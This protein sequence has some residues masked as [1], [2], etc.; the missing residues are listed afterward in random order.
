MRRGAGWG[1]AAA[2]TLLA[3]RAVA[4]CALGLDPSLMAHDAGIPPDGTSGQ[5][6][7]ASKDG[8]DAAPTSSTGMTCTVDSDCVGVVS[9][10]SCVT[11]ATCDAVWHVCMLDVC[12]P[13][14]CQIASCDL[15]QKT[16]SAPTS[17]GFAV[18]VFHIAS[19]VGDWGPASSVAAAYPF[20]F[21]LTNNGVAAYN[22]ANPTGTVPPA[23]AVHGA[24][25]IPVAL[26]A[27]GRRVY[28]VGP[29]EGT[30]PAFRQAIAWID[31]PGDPFLTSLSASTAWVSTT[32]PTLANAVWNGATGLALTYAA[33]ADPTSTL[34]A[35]PDDSTSLV[36]SPIASLMAGAAI[37]ASSGNDLV[38]YLNGTSARHALFSLVTGVSQS[39]GQATAQQNIGAYGPLDDQAAFATGTD[40]TLLWSSAP[41]RVVDGG[42]TGIASTRLTWLSRADAGA[43]A[44]FLST[45]VH[46]DL[47]TY[48]AST[49]GTVV[50]PV[51]Y[52]DN[53]TAV[54]LAASGEDL[55]ATSVQ[56][57][58]RSANAIA[59]GQRAVISATPDAVGVAASH[60][61]AYVLVQDDA[62]NQ[63]STVYVV[64]PGCTGGAPAPDAGDGGPA[65]EGGPLPEG[66]A[67]SDGGTIHGQGGFR[68]LN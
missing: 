23:V 35:A 1:A 7:L 10:G 56:V 55:G 13:G 61:F 9:A 21:V 47:E 12:D 11:S 3:A 67:S 54:A 31:V 64:A 49:S 33:T 15:L 39:T 19:G 41:L 60:G 34:P 18:S 5:V 40:S 66:G 50:G 29:V 32:Q 46:A 17:Y 62:T 44:G 20:L 8:G 4:G 38:A 42:V 52:V 45:A 59:S 58:S 37:V 48:P 26:V 36:P 27:S 25:F 6:S 68:E 43:D 16:C 63:S 65:P 22:V 53:D 57:F 2:G 14:A 51:A 30:G 28:F 24:P